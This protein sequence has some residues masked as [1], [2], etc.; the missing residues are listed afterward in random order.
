MHTGGFGLDHFDDLPLEAR[1]RASA[2]W[3]LNDD[4][5]R[6]QKKKVTPED[7]Q[8]PNHFQREASI[9]TTLDEP[10]DE[11]GSSQR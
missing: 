10:N 2:E 3:H 11:T 1:R 7:R 5:S 4:H 9:S 6:P 8:N